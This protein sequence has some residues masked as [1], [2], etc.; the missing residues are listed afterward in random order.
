MALDL[1]EADRVVIGT[2]EYPIRSIGEWTPGS[3]GVRARLCTQTISTKRADNASGKFATLATKLTGVKAS[4]LMP[5]KEET[6]TSPTLE[7]PLKLYE[8]YL[9]GT[10]TVY[11]VVVEERKA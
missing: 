8:I 10:D 6:E 9:D 1:R 5:M 11:R 4:V 3:K 7:Q 2:D